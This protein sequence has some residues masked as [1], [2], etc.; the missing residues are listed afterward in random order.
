[1]TPRRRQDRVI[2]NRRFRIDVKESRKNRNPQQNKQSQKRSEDSEA[3][4]EKKGNVEEKEEKKA[5]CQCKLEGSCTGKGRAPCECKKG[6]R[7]CT[8]CIA[9]NCSNGQA[10]NP[11]KAATDDKIKTMSA[12]IA[13]LEYALEQEKLKNK[14]LLEELGKLKEK[15]KD[16]E[17]ELKLE[18]ERAN[19][20]RRRMRNCQP[21]VRKKEETKGHCQKPR[22][23]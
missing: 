1:M 9:I 15:R 17:M 19:Q 21:T 6:K 4:N 16:E 10:V 12:T 22:A 8:N 3:K 23:I 5:C 13:Q 11:K 18:K 20:T 2:S 7:H 14:S